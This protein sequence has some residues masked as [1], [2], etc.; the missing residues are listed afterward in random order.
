MRPTDRFP[1]LL[2]GIAEATSIRLQ[3]LEISRLCAEVLEA[4]GLRLWTGNQ[5]QGAT[6]R[7]EA[8]KAQGFGAHGLNDLV[9]Y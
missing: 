7:S 4:F 6:I 2:F 8:P 1:G 3:K 9:C 5:N